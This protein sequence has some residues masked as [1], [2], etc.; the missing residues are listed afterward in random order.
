[1]SELRPTTGRSAA[2]RLRA[3]DA[4]RLVAALAVVLFHFT[5]RDHV[6]WGS[7]RLP[8]DV[9]GAFSGVTVYGY[10]G[11][12]LFFVV[13]GFVILM[14]VWGRSV[15]QFLAS[16]VSRLYPAYWV[17]VLLTA[18][19]RWWWPTFGTVPAGA[20]AVN[21]TMTQDAFHVERVDGVYW[22]LWV[23]LQ[24]YLLMLG[25]LL[26]GITARRVLAVA[27]IAPPAM[28]ALSFLAPRAEA[29]VGLLGWA[30]LFAAGMVL[31]VIHR[32]GSSLARWAVVVGNALLA[33]VA[34][35]LR[36]V[37]AIDAVASGGHVVPVVL[38]AVAVAVV[39][40]VAAVALVPTLR[41]LDWAILTALGA[42][43]YP[44]YLIH[45]YVGWAI[46]ETTHEALGRWLTLAVAVGGC[47]GLAWLLHRFV[48]EPVHRPMRRWL[49]TRFER[50]GELLRAAV[51]RPGAVAADARGTRGTGRAPGRTSGAPDRLPSPPR[52]PEPVPDRTRG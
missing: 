34:S 49:Q 52:A 5:A 20:V 45:E 48:E 7:D 50:V 35:G 43:T 46:I 32:E 16:R 4:L 26:W 12:H 27:A 47:L 29:A 14:S 36:T 22:T 19:L 24:F 3:M 2:P 23:E 40:L 28:V 11:V 33:A 6:R 39:G 31:F 42:L 38:G 15:P 8:H 37:G 1:M 21:L 44:L 30:P 51:R 10:A 17:A 25:F 18:T 13:S 41:D 9:F